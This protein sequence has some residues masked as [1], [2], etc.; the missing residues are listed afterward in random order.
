M[1]IKHYLSIYKRILSSTAS[2]IIQYRLNFLI[3]SLYGPTYV[4]VMYF[5]LA[6]AY[7]KT[8]TLGGFTSNEGLLLFLVFQWLFLVAV[9]LFMKG[10]RVFLWDSLRCGDLDMVLTKPVNAQL[11]VMFSHPEFEHMLLLIFLTIVLGWFSLPFLALVGILDI[12]GFV[13]M[14]LMGLIITYF[15]VAICIATGFYMTRAGQVLEL[16]NKI[17]DFAQYPLIIFPPAFQL[18]G[19]TLVPIAFFSY[20]PTMFLLGRGQ[21]W[22]ILI[23]IFV[24]VVLAALNSIIWNRSLKK[25]SSASS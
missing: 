18:L 25:Y 11:M 2:Q 6:I 22:Y 23:S 14:S 13:L 4:L 16:Y 1:R 17:S 20:F 24:I 8:D 12:V 3:L 7:S 15:S 9:I 21:L 5:L 10:A 19:A